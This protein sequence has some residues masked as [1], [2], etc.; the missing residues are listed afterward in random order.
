MLFSDLAGKNVAI[1]GFGREGQ[2]AL[3]AVLAGA[4]T[5]T[6]TVVEENEDVAEKLATGWVFPH[7]GLSAGRLE[8]EEL[9]QFDVLVKSPGISLYR[10]DLRTAKESGLLVT[11]LTS[12]WLSCHP[13]VPVVAVTG[14]KG[15]S[16]TATLIRELLAWDGKKIH[17]RG[18]VGR[19][20][21]DA[22]EPESEADLVVLELSSF[23]LAD[24]DG[25]LDHLVITN[26]FPAH[27]DWHTSADRYFDDKM[28]ATNLA[29]VV[30]ANAEDVELGRR[31]SA[32]KNVL[33]YGAE[34]GLHVS[35]KGIVRD[36]SVLVKIG[37]MTLPGR[38]NLVNACA[39]LS[40]AL[41]LGVPE[42]VAIRIVKKFLPLPH[43]LECVAERKGRVFVN[44]S[45]AT[46]PLA[47]MAALDSFPDRHVRLILGGVDRGG[48]LSQL[49]EAIAKRNSTVTVTVTGPLGKRLCV[50]C[51][52]IEPHWADDLRAAVE[53]NWNGSC[54][55][56]VILMSP[57][58]PS[59]DAFRD[60]E[61]RGEAFRKIVKAIVAKEG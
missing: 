16:T 10:N 8:V 48:D 35:P 21:F 45:I 24:L 22:D 23:H 15:K 5:A 2:R 3:A 29:A 38:H 52:D 41:E 39:A 1:L 31:L 14:T 54:P 53:E 30:H 28:R 7:V 9:C 17:L 47:T 6:V 51:R 26:L 40:V 57:A 37:E 50:E 44:D 60:F 4:P 49:S 11:S 13:H 59:F 12:L 34:S 43:R 55:G 46:T 36:G 25:A 58:A 19:P 61:A 20:L 27:T 42:D 18:N 33:W 32:R 56:D